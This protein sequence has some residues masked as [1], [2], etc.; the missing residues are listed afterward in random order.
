M[1]FEEALTIVRGGGKGVKRP[2]SIYRLVLIGGK[3][4][5]QQLSPPFT[6]IYIM[7]CDDLLANDWEIVE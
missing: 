1:I 2:N 5:M 6:K 3:S 4:V 7:Y